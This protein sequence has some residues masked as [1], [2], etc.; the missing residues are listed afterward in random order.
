[1][2]RA[3][4]HRPAL[5]K[6]TSALILF[7]LPWTRSVPAFLSS[8]VWRSDGRSAGSGARGPQAPFLHDV[9]QLP[10]VGLGDAVVW[11]Q[12][13]R[14]EVIGFGFLQLPVEVEDRPQVHQGGRILKATQGQERFN[15]W[16]QLRRAASFCSKEACSGREQQ[17]RTSPVI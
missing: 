16:Q 6:Q 8:Q 4:R 14:S 12:S 13:E 17:S 1:M 10:Q 3:A 2:R 5:S 15:T 9:P 7:H 11:F